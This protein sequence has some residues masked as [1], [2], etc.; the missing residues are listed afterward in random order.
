MALEV[1]PCRPEEQLAGLTP[2]FHYFGATPK[3]EYV[4]RFARLQPPERL[5]A[6]F[7]DGKAVGG[8]GVFPFR[9]TVPGA[10]VPAAGV[11]TVG[12]LP[13]HRRRGVLTAMMRAQLDD[14]RER[15]ES[16][17]ALWASE[18]MIY[19]RYG[20]GMASLAG[21]IEL[22]RERARFALPS[23]PVG[24]M[25][26]VSLEDA[27]EAFPVIYDRVAAATPGMFSRT[28][29]W[30]EARRLSDPPERRE[31]GGEHVR[32]L[33]EIDGEPAGY[34]IYRIHMRLERGVATGFV[35]V[36]ESMGVTPA[37]VREVWRFLLGIDWMA[38]IRADLLP[39]DHP[40]SF[41]LAEP[42]RLGFR[43][44]DGL[45][46]R[47]VELGSAFSSRS[48]AAD[49]AVVFDVADA[50]CPWNAG[51]WK[52][53]GGKAARTGE[54]ADLRLDVSALG[55]VYL[56]GFTF[57]QLARAGRVAEVRE[58]AVARADD[59]FRC[60]RAPWCPEIF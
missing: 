27:L 13:T 60:A 21:G 57:A 15:G 39:I 53:E 58:G 46:L 45:W 12:V 25:R 10:Q 52:L 24:R 35:N 47:L 36:L 43:V 48:Y 9:M 32:A 22:A 26:L 50:F 28:H 16:I 38:T 6:A 33:L 44:R 29:D 11:T 40:L 2:I 19:G 30:W 59:L 55:S 17:A 8:A 5:H 18:D 41:L 14:V 7:E 4:Q 42:R 37:A 51:S 31:G 20:Y 23:E 49:G 56:G 1:R 34:A 3:E 54:A